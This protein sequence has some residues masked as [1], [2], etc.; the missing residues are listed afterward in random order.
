MAPSPELVIAGQRSLV[1]RRLLALGHRVELGFIHVDDAQVLH[2]DAPAV[3][4]MSWT[5]VG[6]SR[7]MEID[8]GDRRF[9]PRPVD[10]PV[11]RAI[12]FAAMLGRS[13]H[14]GRTSVLRRVPGI[15]GRRR[16]S[17]R[18]RRSTSLRPGRSRCRRSGQAAGPA[19]ARIWARGRGSGAT[20][21][22]RAH[23]AMVAREPNR[24]RP[25]LGRSDRGT[26]L[27]RWS[28]REDLTGGTYR[29]GTERPPS[30]PDSSRRAE[31]GRERAPPGASFQLGLSWISTK[32]LSVP[33]K[34]LMNG[35]IG[36]A[37]TRTL[38]AAGTYIPSDG[39]WDVVSS[40]TKWFCP[41]N[42]IPPMFHTTDSTPGP[43]GAVPTGSHVNVVPPATAT[44]VPLIACAEVTA[45][46]VTPKLPKLLPEQSSGY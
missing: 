23:P 12:V 25:A 13:A 15:H 11:S 14:R 2:R 9:L 17:L 26:G 32:A 5:L 28:G 27:V 29:A 21:A 4:L 22:A 39:C 42:S 38:S 45:R 36:A 6:R 16:R 40:C 35:S 30:P 31:R 10:Y 8:N 1:E 33:S 37:G 3:G 44:T 7:D 41:M 46:L 18:T 24:D 43:F 34:Q 19:A 20:L